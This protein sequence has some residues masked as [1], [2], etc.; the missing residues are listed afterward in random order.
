M[1][2]MFR[3]Y[4]SFF[5]T[6][7]FKIMFIDCTSS[8]DVAAPVSPHHQEVSCYI[9]YNISMEPHNLWRVVCT[10][11]KIK[12]ILFC[13]Q[14]VKHHSQLLPIAANFSNLNDKRNVYIH[15]K[16]LISCPL[17]LEFE[18]LGQ[19]SDFVFIWI[20]QGEGWKCCTMFITHKK[21]LSLNFH[22]NLYRESCSLSSCMLQKG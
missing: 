22:S 5:L 11:I 10:T 14:F 9:N 4:P 3:I 16:C 8:H 21:R 1:L 2:T 6:L 13:D 17:L 18:I 19:L 20:L 15:L 7:I 12:T